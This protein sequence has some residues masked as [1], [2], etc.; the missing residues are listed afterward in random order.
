MQVE[1][2]GASRRFGK[3]R[4]LDE[5]SLR[6]EP[7]QLVAVLGLNG[8][9]K[10]TL[11]R[12]LAGVIGVDR[13]DV[14]FDGRSFRRDDLAVRRRFFLFARFSSSLLGSLGHA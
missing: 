10:T 4:A 6:I 11:L 14:L 8:A 7:G 5:V 13:G 2:K 9:G 3:V 12:C 1:L